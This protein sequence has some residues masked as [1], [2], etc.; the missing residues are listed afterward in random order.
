MLRLLHCRRVYSMPQRADD[1]DLGTED[2]GGGSDSDSPAGRQSLWR[3]ASRQIDRTLRLSKHPGDR[4]RATSEPIGA[5][6]GAASSKQAGGPPPLVGKN[7]SG[8]K[9]WLIAYSQ[10]CFRLSL[11][12]T[13]AAGRSAGIDIKRQEVSSPQ[14][15]ITTTKVKITVIDYNGERVIRHPSLRIGQLDDFLARNPRPPW[16]KVRWINVQVRCGRWL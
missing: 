1:E 16:A 2:Q 11:T 9:I 3:W 8:N 14:D 5:E 12:S 10:L 15:N 13:S 6:Q 4:P 7:I